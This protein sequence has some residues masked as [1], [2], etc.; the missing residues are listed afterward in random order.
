MDTDSHSTP[1]SDSLLLVRSQ[2]VRVPAGAVVGSPLAEPVIQQSQFS[3]PPEPISTSPG[4][5]AAL[6]QLYDAA[7]KL[8]YPHAA[9]N[10]FFT[11][12]GS[13]TSNHQNTESH[14]SARSA[15]PAADVGAAPSS[16]GYL[17]SSLTTSTTR[18]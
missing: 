16:N 3:S 2:S 9:L 8:G 15:T 1:S 5:E 12:S 11:R 6:R 7:E 4:D 18:D 10:K 14:V 17:Q 13:V